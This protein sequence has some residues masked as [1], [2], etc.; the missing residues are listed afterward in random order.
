MHFE[1]HES[2]QR[3]PAQP[4]CPPESPGG[5]VASCSPGVGRGHEGRLDPRRRKILFRAWHRGMREVD[6]L[7]GGF[8]EARL[9]GLSEAELDDLEA[10]MEAPDRDIF[11]WLIGEAPVPVEYDS[12]V[13]AMIRAFHRHD[14]P[15]FG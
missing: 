6:L 11:K 12:A 4:S 7:V 14:G 15:V 1:R 3:S 2:Y 9:A 5:S 13:F 8:A 10:L